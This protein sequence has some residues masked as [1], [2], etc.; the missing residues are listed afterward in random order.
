LKQSLGC[1]ITSWITLENHKLD[2]VEIRNAE[3]QK[4]CSWWFWIAMWEVFDFLHGGFPKIF[5]SKGTYLWVPHDQVELRMCSEEWRKRRMIWPHDQFNRDYVWS[6]RDEREESSL[7]PKSRVTYNLS[8][9]SVESCSN[10][11]EENAKRLLEPKWCLKINFISVTCSHYLRSYEI[12]VP[13]IAWITNGLQNEISNFPSLTSSFC[14]DNQL[15]S[16]F[17]I[18]TQWSWFL[19]QNMWKAP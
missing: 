4:G 18:F 19:W 13:K 11:Y 3:D 9:S 8:L 1:R 14:F 16:K 6:R 15:R 5:D 2:F 17:E 12:W 7:I 10:N